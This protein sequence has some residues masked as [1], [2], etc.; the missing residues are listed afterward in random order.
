MLG[1][2]GVILKIKVPRSLEMAIPRHLK[3]LDQGTFQQLWFK[4][5]KDGCDM[6]TNFTTPADLIYFCSTRIWK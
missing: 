5:K 3:C 6:V 4:R 1:A 2:E